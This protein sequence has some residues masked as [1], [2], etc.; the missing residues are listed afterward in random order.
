MLVNTR[1]H[2][3]SERFLLHVRGMLRYRWQAVSFA[4]FV[5]LAGWALVALLPN[6]YLATAR[7]YVDTQSIL[8]PLLAGLAM[9]P[10]DTQIVEM[11]SRTLISRPNVERVIGM[12]GMAAN[13][14]T[15]AEFEELVTRLNRELTIKTT[16]AQRNFYTI[17]YSDKD[18]QQ[19]KRVVQ[20]LLTIFVE[21]GQGDK[22]KDSDS[23]RVFIDDQLKTYAERLTAA[24]DA[25][26]EFKRR[27]V[28]L[29]PGQGQ[30][31]FERMSVARTELNQARL[32]LA[33]AEQGR[34]A[35]RRRLASDSPG[36]MADER[37]AEATGSRTPVLEVT[38]PELDARIQALQQRLDTL[39]LSYTEQHPDIVAAVASMEQLQGQ[40][41]R[42][43][44]QKRR[45]L[46][47][48]ERAAA[49][50]RKASPSSPSASQDPVYQKLSIS[51]A[52]FEASVASL[53]ARVAEYDRRVNELRATANAIPK[54][55][56]EYTQLTRDY[57]VTKRNYDQLVSRRESA[58]ITSDMQ[59]TSNAMDFRVI[60][61]PQVPSKPDWPHRRLFM[62]AVLL[63]AL[64]AG[65]GL[66]FL[67]SQLRP[68]IISERQLRELSGVAVYGTVIMAW[69][70]QQVR[71][72]KR[73]RIVVVASLAGLVIAYLAIMATLMAPRLAGIAALLQK[74]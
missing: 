39:R 72:E 48:K 67:I 50:V 29:M 19:A 3:M 56:A 7:V 53:R 45:D 18:P 58:Q 37:P 4:W 35:I 15:E 57:E 68:T 28:G 54:V 22:R 65:A 11:M 63:A 6:R 70:D 49:R 8:K 16:A 33:E 27:N 12:S 40:K 1:M 51:L 74:Q 62:S 14:K 30:N 43:M 23:A 25:V 5:A 36:L 17:A 71:K 52:E 44:D 38:T 61:P 2:E 66:A 64:A 31:Y 24:E 59:S 46:E 9:Q 20:S 47:E 55:E 10:N 41:R 42:E 32:E 69:N 13:A 26:T 60:D 34:D 73:Q 21:G